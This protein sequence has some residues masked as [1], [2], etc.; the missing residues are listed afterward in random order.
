MTFDELQELLIERGYRRSMVIRDGDPTT[1]VYAGYYVMRAVDAGGVETFHRE[2]GTEFG[3]VSYSTDADACAALASVL[4]GPGQD[5]GSVRPA[6]PTPTTVEELKAAL[7]E[8]GR[9]PDAVTR[10]EVLRNSPKDGVSVVDTAADG[11]CRTSFIERA[12]WSEATTRPSEA[13]AI[14]ELTRILLNPYLESPVT[15]ERIARMR[16]RVDQYH[17]LVADSRSHW[18]NHSTTVRRDA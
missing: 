6:G 11:T 10:S 4:T 18:W 12:Q 17:A 14:A 1:N 15:D 5:R 7:A 13:L 16:I 9:D 8:H 3:A 2:R